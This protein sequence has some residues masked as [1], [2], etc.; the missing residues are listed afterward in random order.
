MRILKRSVILY[1]LIF[2][3]LAFGQ[4]QVTT[5]QVK[6]SF[7][8]SLWYS[9]SAG[10]VRSVSLGPGILITQ[11]PDGTYQLTV[12]ITL[13]PSFKVLTVFAVQDQKTI[14]TEATSVALVYRNG[15]L[16]N[17]ISGLNVVPDYTFN[18]TTKTIIFTQPLAVSDIIKVFY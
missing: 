16:Q 15:I 7:V 17:D 10:K 12:Q 14:S 11:N 6:S 2:S 3:L 4:T 5:P 1:F 9:D 8:S 13:T 18:T